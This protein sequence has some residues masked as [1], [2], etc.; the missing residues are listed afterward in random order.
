MLAPVVLSICSGAPALGFDFASQLVVYREDYVG[1]VAYPT[2]P[3][4]DEIA[5]GGL[6]AEAIPGPG[7]G[8]VL[9]DLAAHA[10][11]SLGDE[12]TTFFGANSFGPGS[13]GIRG[14][15]SGM[16]LSSNSS[17]AAVLKG[18]FATLTDD[19]DIDAYVGAARDSMGDLSDGFFGIVDEVG[20]VTQV[21]L[22][23]AEAAALAG[24]AEFTLDLLVDRE[25]AS[26]A[27][28][29]DIV[30]FSTRIVGP[31]S[32]DPAAA[33]LAVTGAVQSLG[34]NPSAALLEVDFRALEIYRTFSSSFVVDTTEDEVDANVGDGTCESAN[35]FCSLRAAIQESNALEGPG[36][37]SLPSGTYLLSIAGA[38]ED[39]GE[40][41]DLDILDDLVL[42]GAG[43]DV[44]VIDGAKLDRVMDVPYPATDTT[45]HLM[46]LEITNGDVEVTQGG[47]V[48]NVGRLRLQRCFVTGNMAPI[49]GGI[50]NR[51]DL[52]LE[53]CVVTGNEAEFTA[54]GIASGS[55]SAGG[56]DLAVATLRRS[57]VVGNVAPQASGVEFGNATSARVE[58]TTISGNSGGYQLS[59]NNTNVVLQHA[60]LVADAGPAVLGGSF[61]GTDTFEVS[62][63]VIAGAPA[64]NLST[65]FPA[66]VVLLG[67][68]ASNDTTCGFDAEGD[69]EGV[70]LGLAVLAPVG[71]SQAH[72]PEEGSPL[73]DSAELETCLFEDQVGIAR[74]MD[75]DASG[76][77]ECDIGAIEV[78]EPSAAMMV[79]SA[80]LAV[81]LLAG[82]RARRK[83]SEAAI[84]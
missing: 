10:S 33:G 59:F 37:I 24:G 43:R 64:C 18:F 58:N 16:S 70:S 84:R 42:Q 38:E 28:S 30:G 48:Q 49:G 9:S 82:C 3:E 5:A 63:S 61:D 66:V 14:R 45:A 78:P 47:G 77:A 1:E 39:L 20:M 34:A 4:V 51:G 73:V 27:A 53:D 75:G 17:G 31:I 15:Y 56:S 50:M 62:N 76:T 79:V 35:G 55:T 67:H 8:P 83:P 32:I 69:V 12:Q 2:M 11:V 72:V 71:D 80:L 25:L 23:E 7:A 22:S 21:T 13:I 19:I 44:T 74:P 40:T 60:T 68:N 29:L 54:G 52:L 65:T 81:H 46:D 26:A 6:E 36:S 57:A 41:G